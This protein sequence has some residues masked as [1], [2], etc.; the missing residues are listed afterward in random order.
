MAFIVGYAP[1]NNIVLDASLIEN[2]AIGKTKKLISI[3]SKKQ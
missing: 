1:Q 2:I 3:K